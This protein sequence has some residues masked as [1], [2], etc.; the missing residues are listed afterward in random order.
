[1]ETGRFC[2]SAPFPFVYCQLLN[3]LKIIVYNINQFYTTTI[4]T[5]SDNNELGFSTL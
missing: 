2:K 5:W 4:T 3:D 1:M